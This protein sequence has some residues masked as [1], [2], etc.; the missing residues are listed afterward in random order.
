[1]RLGHHIR[2]RKFDD[3]GGV[4]S[5]GDVVGEYGTTSAESTAATNCEAAGGN[6]TGFTCDMSNVTGGPLSGV[7]NASGS[8]FDIL[9][10]YSQD[11]QAMAEYLHNEYGLQDAG[12][13]LKSFEAYNPEKEYN[14]Q[15]SY[16]IGVEGAQTGARQQMGDIYAKAR[17]ASLKGGG[18]GGKGKTLANMK[19]K[20]LGNFEQQQNKLHTS[21]AQGVQ[22][23]REDYSNDW[24]DQI[25]KLSSMGAAFCKPDEEYVEDKTQEQL[26][27]G[28]YPKICRK[29]A[30]D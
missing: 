21:F 15:D 29:K 13:Y 2:I 18:F 5:P 6:W 16:R 28:G 20:T 3:G 1:M 22:G 23:L 4:G 9:S 26:R 11:P 19:G 24:L 17:Q 12:Q 27:N 8:Q 7:N 14:L 25:G 30:A 10:G